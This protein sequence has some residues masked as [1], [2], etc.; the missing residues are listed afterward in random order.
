MKLA[1]LDAW[2]QTQ[3][4]TGRCAFCPELEIVGPAQEVREQMRDHLASEHPENLRKRRSHRAR[5]N[6]AIMS[7]RQSLTDDEAFE[8]EEERRRRM[9]LLGQTE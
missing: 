4:M 7:F 8:I 3:L 9:K 1:E 2:Y 5:R 6:P